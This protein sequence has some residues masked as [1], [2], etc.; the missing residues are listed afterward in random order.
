MDGFEAHQMVPTENRARMLLRNVAGVGIGAR[1]R[2]RKR[3]RRRRKREG[4]FVEMPVRNECWKVKACAVVCVCLGY[5]SIPPT[6]FD[7][8]FL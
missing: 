1:R 4:V 6:Q 5:C 8:S 7:L 2:R 3:R